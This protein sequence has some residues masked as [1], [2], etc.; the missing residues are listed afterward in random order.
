MSPFCPARGL[1]EEFLIQSEGALK[2]CLPSDH[3]K[4]SNLNVMLP[5]FAA[6]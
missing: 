1:P 5:G 4:D 3:K 2:G 6:F